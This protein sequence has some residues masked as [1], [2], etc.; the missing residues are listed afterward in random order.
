MKMKYEK[1]TR[2][3][4]PGGDFS[5]E[6]LNRILSKEDAELD[7]A[8]FDCL[9][10]GKMPAGT[11]EEVRYY[12]PLTCAYIENQRDACDFFEHFSIWIEDNYARLKEDGLIAPVVS[13][14]HNLFRKATTSFSLEY[15]GDHAVYPAAC[16]S[17]ESVLEAM[18]R[19][20]PACPEFRPDA[21]FS[22]LKENMNFVHA[23]WIVYIS[24]EMAMLSPEKIRTVVLSSDYQKA[25][26][27]IEENIDLI[28]NDATA[29]DFWKGKI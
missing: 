29:Y 20:S 26:A 6:E 27:V 16:A 4:D 24:T 22:E 10:F 13:A 12:I 1:P 19:L 14:F 25:L 8:D 28:L 2:L 15:N 11:Y 17:V 5:P 21:L 18:F 23:Q 7:W 3:S 9:F